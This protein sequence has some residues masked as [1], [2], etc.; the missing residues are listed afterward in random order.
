MNYIAQEM[1]KTN[2]AIKRLFETNI[3]SHVDC[4]L[5]MMQSWTLTL[6]Y[7]S[8]HPLTQT[9]LVKALN[10]K[11]SSVSSML[12]V[13]EKKGYIYRKADEKDNRKNVLM[14]DEKAKVLVEMVKAQVKATELQ[15][16]HMLT[17]EEAIVFM[18]LLNKIQTQ[19]VTGGD[20]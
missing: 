18:Q 10:I 6:I 11:K 16:Q 19:C 1:K 12:S 8:D 5:T 7:Q 15:I 3:K 2:K 14:L 17:E 13:M 20:K 9:D 4:D